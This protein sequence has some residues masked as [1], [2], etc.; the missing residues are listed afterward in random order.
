[1]GLDCDPGSQC[2][3]ESAEAPKTKDNKRRK[4]KTRKT[5]G[6]ASLVQYTGLFIP[7]FLGLEA[8]AKKLSANTRC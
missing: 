2:D 1:M 7:A 3:H 8:H 6:V 4:A 5:N